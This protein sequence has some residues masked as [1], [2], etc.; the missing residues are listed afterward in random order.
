MAK[1]K[2]SENQSSC[3]IVQVNMFC[4]V[5]RGQHCGVRVSKPA[6]PLSALLLFAGT[7]TRGCTLY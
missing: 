1:R 4:E 7:P 3:F 5:Y 2:V 6:Y